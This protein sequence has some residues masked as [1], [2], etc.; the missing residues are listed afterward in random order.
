MAQIILL[1]RGYARDP[2]EA[3]RGIVVTGCAAAL[4][5]AGPFFPAL[6]F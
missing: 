6:N 2:A 1:V 5:M 4:I 3:V